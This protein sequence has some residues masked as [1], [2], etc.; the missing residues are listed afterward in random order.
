MSG[1]GKRVL[2]Y[3]LTLLTAPMPVMPFER[4]TREFAS[5]VIVWGTLLAL[6]SFYTARGEMKL[7]ARPLVGTKLLIASLF[8]LPLGIFLVV[9]AIIYLVRA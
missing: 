6:S 8:T 3:T 4:G 7:K 5:A 1:R 9:W 2:V